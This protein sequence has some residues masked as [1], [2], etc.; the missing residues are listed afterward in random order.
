[1]FCRPAA[2][3]CAALVATGLQSAASRHATASNTEPAAVLNS[4]SWAILWR[5]PWPPSRSASSRNHSNGKQFQ[6][7]PAIPTCIS[8]QLLMEMRMSTAICHKISSNGGKGYPACVCLGTFPDHESGDDVENDQCRSSGHDITSQ[9]LAPQG[10]FG[11]CRHGRAASWI[12]WS[13]SALGQRAAAAAVFGVQLQ[14][15]EAPSGCWH[16]GRGA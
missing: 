14:W 10:R 11:T 8:K 15:L 5:R 2:S 3:A 7:D 16:A 4:T 13:A 6:G 9:Q 1:M 12:C